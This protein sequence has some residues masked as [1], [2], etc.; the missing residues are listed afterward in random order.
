MGASTRT[1]KA[2]RSQSRCRPRLRV[3]RAIRAMMYD[4]Y[5]QPTARQL[6]AAFTTEP[7]GIHTPNKTFKTRFSIKN[8][9]AHRTCHQNHA[10]TH[11]RHTPPPYL[12]NGPFCALC[13]PL[14]PITIRNIENNSRTKIA[15]KLVLYV[16]DV[17]SAPFLPSPPSPQALI[18]FALT[19]C[20]PWGDT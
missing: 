17:Q 8:S 16:H 5:L 18:T 4:M 14:P 2:S 20:R 15:D 13:L 6:Q 12:S 3:I 19:L 9:Q 7:V 1:V 11:T 10:R